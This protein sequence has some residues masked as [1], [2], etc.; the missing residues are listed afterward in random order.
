MC[1]AEIFCSLCKFKI[2]T[3]VHDERN[4]NNGMAYIENP[5]AQSCLPGGLTLTLILVFISM[6]VIS[7]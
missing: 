4:A 2:V 3:Y 5:P 1:G 7:H 6:S